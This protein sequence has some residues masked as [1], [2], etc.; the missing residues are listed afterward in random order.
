MLRL[1]KAI[2]MNEGFLEVI[3]FKFII[4]LSGPISSRIF[5]WTFS[6]DLLI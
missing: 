3:H 5:R 2:V 6:P 4:G 1:A